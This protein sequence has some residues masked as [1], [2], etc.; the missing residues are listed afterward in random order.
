[1][2]DTIGKQEGNG[3]MALQHK[4]DKMFPFS[5]DCAQKD[6]LTCM[7]MLIKRRWHFKFDD[8]NLQLIPTRFTS[9]IDQR[10]GVQP[11]HTVQIS[12][13]VAISWTLQYCTEV[14]LHS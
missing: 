5:I 4:G 6:M 3:P 10:V 9:L 14:D 11:I 2:S 1:M 12:A 13:E 7:C 8:C